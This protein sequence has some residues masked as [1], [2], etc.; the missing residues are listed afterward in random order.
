MWIMQAAAAVLMLLGSALIIRALLEVDA[1]F[2]PADRRINPR[3]LPQPRTA[4][5]DL[6]TRL[7]RA[8]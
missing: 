3:S 4:E 8:A 2:R 5:A 1:P 7:P 6:E